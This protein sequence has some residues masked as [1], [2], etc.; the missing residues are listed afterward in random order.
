MNVM[1]RAH[2]HLLRRLQAYVLDRQRSFHCL[3]V[4]FRRDFPRMPH[5]EV[6]RCMSRSQARGAMTKRKD[7]SQSFNYADFNTSIWDLWLFKVIGCLS[8]AL[9]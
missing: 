7:A 3:P 8:N 1:A 6:H 9:Q 2:I 4:S 5:V